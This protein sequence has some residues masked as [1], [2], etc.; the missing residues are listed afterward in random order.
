MGK[1]YLDRNEF[2]KE[3]SKC[4]RNGELSK[5][6]LDMLQIFCAEV[7]R[8]FF[9]ADAEDQKDAIATSLHDC[10][11]YWKGFKESNLVQ[12]Q[13]NN[14]FS[15]GDEIVIFINNVGE[16]KYT[17]SENS[18]I[19]NREF[20]I[21][22]IQ[23]KSPIQEHFYKHVKTDIDLEKW[24]KTEKFGKNPT[25]LEKLSLKFKKNR[26]TSINRELENFATVIRNR[27]GLYLEVFIDKV[28]R[29]MTIMDKHNGSV[30]SL[31]SYIIIN[32]KNED[33]ITPNRTQKKLQ[34]K[35]NNN[36][37]YFE[38]PPNAFSYYT[39]LIRNGIIKSID[40]LSPKALRN[41]MKLSMS[42]TIDEDGNGIF[43]F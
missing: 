11:K 19:L 34:Q 7:S 36:F 26:I 4:K 40:K 29:K 15:V 38:E 2:H 13:F 35:H 39:S 33:I 43:K 18:D 21:S 22:P 6:A 1:H 28:K 30:K 9:F 8:D 12:L 27:D 14:N 3:M 25:E 42:H 37:F 41:G 17:V 5:T 24:I 10:I 32:T 31:Q 23:I 20:Q 16:F